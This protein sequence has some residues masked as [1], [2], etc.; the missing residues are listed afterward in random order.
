MASKAS[1]SERDIEVEEV[2]E[3]EIESGPSNYSE[4]PSTTSSEI[5]RRLSPLSDPRFILDNNGWLGRV[6]T[7]S[8]H[9][10][11]AIPMLGYSFIL[12]S[13]GDTVLSAPSGYFVVYRLALHARLRFPL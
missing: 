12:L 5:R 7:N 2:N 4:D 1:P 3:V 10:S 13:K 8:R 11:S 6:A 9:F